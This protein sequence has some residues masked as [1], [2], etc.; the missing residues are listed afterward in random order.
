MLPFQCG[1]L[2]SDPEQLR[3]E[4]FQRGREPDCQLGAGGAVDLG[5]PGAG[6]QQLLVQ[7]R[8][9]GGQLGQKDLIE[10]SQAVAPIKVSD[11][12]PVRKERH[13]CAIH[14]PTGWG[15]AAVCMARHR[16]ATGSR[17]RAVC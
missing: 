14:F 15:R 6:L 11:R 2:G 16:P 17:R 3:D 13:F 4:S 12:E 10:P 8:I 7:R 9:G 5:R 1:E